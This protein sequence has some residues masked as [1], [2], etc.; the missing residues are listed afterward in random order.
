MLSFICSRV[1]TGCLAEAIVPFLWSRHVTCGNTAAG[2]LLSSLPVAS[3][4]DLCE[5]ERERE[6][7]GALNYGTFSL[8][9]ADPPWARKIFIFAF[10]FRR[11]TRRIARYVR[12]PSPERLRYSS[13]IISPIIAMIIARRWIRICASEPT[14]MLAHRYAWYRTRTE[15]N[16]YNAIPNMIYL[17]DG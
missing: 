15:A 6:G 5:K 7:A 9:A 11:E 13:S 4:N 2:S 8:R 1:T 16:V 17:M 3:R 14:E 10:L 12:E